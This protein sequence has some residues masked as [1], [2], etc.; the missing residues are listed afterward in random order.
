MDFKWGVC[1]WQSMDG[2]PCCRQKQISEENGKQKIDDDYNLADLRLGYTLCAN[3]GNTGI[4]AKYYPTS[5]FKE[6]QGPNLNT[7]CIGFKFG[8]D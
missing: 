7:F 6:T 5:T 8:L 3:Y 4:Y 1:C 2:M